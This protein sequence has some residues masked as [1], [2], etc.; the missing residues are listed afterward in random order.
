MESNLPLKIKPNRTLK[1]LVMLEALII[2]GLL[3]TLY[4]QITKKTTAPISQE[5]TSTEKVS[6]GDLGNA[7]PPDIQA[8]LQTTAEEQSGQPGLDSEA[9]ELKLKSLNEGQ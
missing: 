9:L 2:V 1:V 4:Y 7:P 3:I 8:R 5:D 6:N